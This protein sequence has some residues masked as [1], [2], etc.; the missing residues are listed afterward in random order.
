M[1]FERLR[2]GDWITPERLRVYPAI[3]LTVFLIATAVV[4]ATAKGGMGPNNLPLGADFSQVWVAGKEARAGAPDAPYDLT[5]HIAAQRAQ[6]GDGTGVFGWHYPPYFLFPAA[7]LARFD[8]LPA[9]AIWQLSTLIAYIATVAPI[10]IGAG[11]RRRDALIAAVAFPAVFVNLWHGQN[12]FFTTALLGGGFTLLDRRP[13][14]SGALFGLL[15]YKPQFVLILPVALLIERRWRALAAAAATLLVI[16]GASIATFGPGVW[17][18]F[19]D[20]LAFTRLMTEQG[21]TGFEKIQSVFAAVRLLGGGVGAAY[22]IQA[23]VAASAL[24]AL[25]RLLLSGA[26][27]RVKA[28]ATI[29]AMF[30]STPYI[31]DYDMV[32]LAPAL[33]LLVAHGREKGFRPYEKSALA[34]AYAAPIFARP[35]ATALPVP[36][37]VVMVGLLFAST[38]RYAAPRQPR[39]DA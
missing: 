6:F 5:R 38:A 10:L 35:V 27:R 22:F 34:L 32:T 33:A 11:L 23:L 24:A 26:D 30:L 28:A 25:L 13:L 18:A 14:A 17:R 20:S 3:L 21:A 8:Y 37:G 12:G 2:S 7:W 4:I 19:F 9:L 36:L 16:T 15:A 29:I 39:A 31:L 1:M